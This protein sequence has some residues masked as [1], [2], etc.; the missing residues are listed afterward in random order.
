MPRTPRILWLF[1]ALA[2]LAML[3]WC[4]AY[5]S[6]WGKGIDFP[7]FY[8][9]ARLVGAGFGHR[10]YDA[11]L[12]WQFQ[13]RLTGRIGTLFNHP[14]FETLVYLPFSRFPYRLA[15]LLWSGFNLLVLAVAAWRLRGHLS[16]P[17][18]L[19]TLFL[20]FLAFP[21]V[22]LSLLQGQDSILLLLA[23]TALIRMPG[24]EL[25]AG[26]WLGLGLIKFQFVLPAALILMARRS[27]PF[28]AGL[29]AAASALLLT[30][31][32]I[33]GPAILVAY[34]RFLRSLDG[35]S[36]SG[37]HPYAMPNLRGL[38][39]LAL[40]SSPRAEPA[41]LLALSVIV[42]VLAWDGWKQA[43]AQRGKTIL[44]VSNTV[45]AA[46]LL[47]YHASPH[48]LTLLTMPLAITFAY[49]G[50]MGARSSRLRVALLLTAVALALPP[51]YVFALR[52]HL[53]SLLAL[54]VLVL[55]V[56]THLEILRPR[57]AVQPE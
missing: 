40:S 30:S 24:H 56:I 15:Y 54:A 48:D 37:I 3:Y 7:E 47:S 8:S 6:R 11:S 46:V 57:D 5:F 19:P 16:A 34:P 22:L 44:A 17:L 39:A 26:L 53:Y 42:F 51:A 33:S 50:T 27:R 41:A 29:A 55:F 38:C 25:E 10:L 21:P 23:F 9:A 52:A 12:Q 43:A 49:L 18:N 13:A 20:L 45:L 28:A 1:A 2:C 36:L 4:S 31:I 14:P 35:V 32:A